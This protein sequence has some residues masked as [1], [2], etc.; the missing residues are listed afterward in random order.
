VSAL[1]DPPTDYFRA[2]EAFDV[3]GASDYVVELLDEGTPI[4]TIT[5]EVL[6]PAQ[7]RVGQLWESGTWSVA[8][9]HVATS[10]T[11]GALSALTHAATPRRAAYTRH[12]ALACVEGEWHA[13]PGRMAA[14][15]AG[16]NGE[17]RVTML[18]ASLPPEQ[19][20]RRLSAGDID[21]LAL[22]CTMPTNLVGAARCIAAAHD[23]DVPVIVGG[24]A[25]GDS[26]HRALAIGADGWAVDAAVLLG[27]I[28]DLAGRSSEVST[29]VL[30][31]DAIDDAVIALAYDRMVGA[32]PRLSSMTHFQQARTHEDLRW[33]ARYTAAAL[34]TNDASVV[35]DLLAWLCGLLSGAVPASV[36]T[37]SAQLLADTLEPRSVSGAAILR[38]AAAKLATDMTG[39]GDDDAR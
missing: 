2:V 8:D 37:T 6:A 32:F 26:P 35:E 10:I 11:E 9:E 12:V 39:F 36:I 31:L 30:L 16:V 5:K 38:H 19:L 20:H 34:L 7:V 25:F 33:M 22:S 17:A 4:E 24:R 1:A 28:P 27:P 23:L 21:V 3:Y 15:V 18:G 29:E 13:L 14:A